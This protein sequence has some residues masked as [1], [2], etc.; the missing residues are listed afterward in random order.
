[1]QRLVVECEKYMDERLPACS[2]EVGY[3][4][5]TSCTIIDLHDVSVKQFWD[6]RSYVS[7]ASQIGQD[8]YPERLGK[9][10]IIAPWGFATIWSIIKGWIDP[11]TQEKI[12]I[13][14][15]DYQ[16]DLLALIPEDNLPSDLGGKCNCPG[17]CSLSDAGLWSDSKIKER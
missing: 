6:V 16:R 15:S 17:G 12:R 5:E 1:M 8:Y 10:F 3:P 13:V 2:A 14:G 4:I 9:L 7:K 11:V